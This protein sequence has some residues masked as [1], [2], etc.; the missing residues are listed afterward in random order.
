MPLR[1]ALTRLVDRRL[2]LLERHLPAALAG[3]ATGVHQARVASR[4]LREAVPV[5][6]ADLPGVRRRKVTRRLRGIT[7]ALGG[8]REMD[9]S[10]KALDGIARRI[11]GADAA[12]LDGV[13]AR[14]ER[15][16]QERRAGMHEALSAIGMPELAGRVRRIADLA[17]SPEHEAAWRTRLAARLA[18][19][20]DA[21][22][23]AIDAAGALYVP[24]PL[25]RVRIAA[26]KLRYA[27]ELAGESGAAETKR[28]V[29]ALKR[30][31]DTLGRLHDLQVLGRHVAALEAEPGPARLP[32]EA[33]A[34]LV[35]TLDRDCRALH[36]RYV[37]AGSDLLAIC[38]AV[39]GAVAPAVAP[40]PGGRPTP[41][42]MTLVAAPRRVP[43]RGTARKR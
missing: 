40:A 27:L 10:L 7:R 11:G 15:V 4:R 42:K 28:M 23:A 30:V 21:L 29:R 6:A 17:S 12:A 39:R 25:H 14:L 18:G 26:K 22:A 35:H 41:L 34:P 33:L 3:D 38:G 20:A 32:A 43:S 5:L 19:R 16:R 37:A 36:A 9:V 31:Q 2:R 1:T 24:E 8:V 13:R